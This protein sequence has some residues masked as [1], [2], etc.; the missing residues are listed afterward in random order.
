M[1]KEKLKEL[2]DRDISRDKI[3]EQISTKK[4][5]PLVHDRDKKSVM[6]K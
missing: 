4:N 3:L 1:E 6:K 2:T 5:V